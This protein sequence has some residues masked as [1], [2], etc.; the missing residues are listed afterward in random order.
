VSARLRA[1]LDEKQTHLMIGY[2]QLRPEV[3]LECYVEKNLWIRYLEKNPPK[4]DPE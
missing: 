2:F 4:P 1:D 3:F